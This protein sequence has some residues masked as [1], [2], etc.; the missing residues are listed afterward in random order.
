M[1][2]QYF[3]RLSLLW[4]GLF[5]L[6]GI[7]LFRFYFLQ[8]VEHDKWLKKATAQHYFFVE[9]PCERGRFFAKGRMGYHPLTLNIPAYHL[10][11]DPKVIPEKVRDELS[12]KVCAAVGDK[13]GAIDVRAQFDKA[14]RARR[15]AAWLSSFEKKQI[16]LW[17]RPFARA[18]K[19]PRNA[20]F[21]IR[22]YERSYPYGH[23]L[24]QILHTVCEEKG[25]DEQR[26]PTGGLELALAK[27]LSGSA[28]KREL[29]R[30][31]RHHI[32]LGKLINAPK[33]GADVYLT[34]DP[35]IQSLAE[36]ELERAVKRTSA[37]G[38]WA[39][40]MDPKTGYI[41]AAAQV[42]FFNPSEYRSYFSDPE[43]T[44]QT[45][46]RGIIDVFEPGSV[47]K[48]FTLAI[49]LLANEEQKI[50]GKQPI[51]DPERKETCG[52]FRVPG[53]RLPLREYLCRF[54][55]LNMAMALKKS[56]NVYMAQ[57]ID[58]VLQAF[59]GPWYRKQ[60]IERF[61]FGRKTGVEL[62]SENAGLIPRIGKRHPNGALEWSKPTP[63]SM[64]FG[65]NMLA[66]SL[67]LVRAYAVFANGGYL[68]EPT[69]IEKID[70]G[71]A[72]IVDHTERRLEQFPQTLPTPIANKIVEA[73]KYTTQ[74]GGSAKRA[75]IPGYTEAGKTGTS[76]KVINGIYSKERNMSYF[77]GMAP[78][79][80]PR[81]VLLIL[82][83]EPKKQYFPGF[84]YNQHAGNCA[85][86]AFATIGAKT[87]DYLGVAPDDPYGYPKGDPRRDAEKADFVW[88]NE[89][90][91]EK[92][93]AWNP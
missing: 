6:F 47:M 81:F 74:S 67:Q 84:G 73:C 65:H 1:N 24:G 15:V 77:I 61:G 26:L 88:E 76:E 11:I 52:Q 14:A 20:L 57:L 54:T 43:K 31:P 92:L 41:L 82:I 45:R 80:N 27:L 21:F 66:S 69:L 48:P 36:V 35:F 68:V 93:K 4:G 63:Y 33:N 83:D 46:Y 2:L 12:A 53:R 51:F 10:F 70:Q 37:K 32:G 91:L 16:E 38:G 8:V 40:M 23:L 64:S 13:H 79:S 58:R 7:L 62:P 87:L 90:L 28:G 75:N 5:F 30:S 50:Q 42:P 55:Y 59:G 86:P 89:A 72:L 9:E 29:M 3:L 18:H 17:W 39:L 85:G 60:L 25:S 56:S 22:D 49:G 34:I 71:G 44:K 78:A 19:I